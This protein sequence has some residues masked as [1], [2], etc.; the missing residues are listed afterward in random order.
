[1]HRV[2]PAKISW[3][4]FGPILLIL[5][6][7]ATQGLI[8]RQWMGVL[9]TLTATAFILY[10][11]LGTRYTLT[12][13]ELRIQSGPFRWRVPVQRIRRVRPSLNPLSAPAPSLDRLKISY[14]KYR[15]VLIS[16]Q[17]QAAFIDALKQLNPHIQLS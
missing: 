17:D 16:P 8:D 10:V 5:L 6:G 14:D 3:W 1:M 13:A 9:I 2:F 7:V 15:F 12:A 11:A 4:L